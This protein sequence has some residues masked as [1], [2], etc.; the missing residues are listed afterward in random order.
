MPAPT[1]LAPTRI[2]APKRPAPSKPAP[3]TPVA[4]RARP[5][6]P[7]ASSSDSPAR[8]PVA[9]HI[10]RL[11]SLPLRVSRAL[12]PSTSTVAHSSS[13]PRL[14]SPLPPSSDAMTSPAADDVET[15]VL[16]AGETLIFGRHRSSAPRVG[17]TT[18]AQ[19]IPSGLKHLVASS[20]SVRIVPLPRGAHHASRVHAA[21]ELVVGAPNAPAVRVL[22]L[23]QNGAR[24]R[25]PAGR[26]VRMAQGMRLDFAHSVTLDF[27]GAK[28][29][30]AAPVSQVE[31]QADV[32]ART[33]DAAIET[34]AADADAHQQDVLTPPPSSP[35]P[36]SS[37]PVDMMLLDNDETDNAPAEAETEA[38][39]PAAP[40]SP[41]FERAP[42]SPLSEV[43]SLS[44]AQDD[45]DDDSDDEEVQASFP[46]EAVHE[47]EGEAAHAASSSDHEEDYFSP[48]PE[49]R[50]SSPG[51]YI[52]PGEAGPD[53]DVEADKADA[54]D[55]AVKAEQLDAAE[56]V[57][58]SAAVPVP[59]DVDLG[60]LIAS[61]VVFSGSSKLSLPDLVRSLLES[62]PSLRTHGAEEQWSIW[63]GT[64]LECN[65][66]FGKV[67]RYGKDSSGRPLLA[68]YYYSPDM[69][70]DAARAKEL[71][72]L[73]RPLRAA[74]RG[75]GK[76]I[77]WRP[78]G[79]GRR[80]Y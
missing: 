38:S 47:L 19:A 13:P 72:G 30:V 74:Q 29:R 32:F 16:V 53:A 9:R 67:E 48:E 51:I 14:S 41:I 33:G 12:T 76:A 17:S 63:A 79:M 21:V 23:G 20:N 35:M 59:A 70:P 69:D 71:G 54:V 37:P 45:D 42:S 39:S 60:A 10:F 66:M 25:P 75:G 50:P 62:Q 43:A 11:P 18:L 15:H 31:A 2:V 7:Q 40:S 4:K 52:P 78:V 46:H 28:V 8:A 64:E 55:R 77:D 3:S 34:D 1:P 80:R 36:P 26:R 24:A 73:V 27:Y 22:V 58:E 61:T 5:L 65:P 44:L 57:A 68:H 49:A 56:A 6:T